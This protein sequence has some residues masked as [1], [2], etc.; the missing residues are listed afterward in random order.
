MT[1]IVL[2]L[3]TTGLDPKQGHKIVEIGAI[4]LKN[5]LLT[6]DKFHRY[7]NPERDMPFQAYNIHGISSSFLA[8]KPIFKDVVDELLEFIKDSTLI[9]HNASFDVKFLNYELALLGRE[10]INVVNVIDTLRVAQNLYPGKKASLDA[11]C[12]RFKV[13]LS[14][15]KLHGALKDAELLA[16]VYYMMTGGVNQ[17]SLEVEQNI[18]EM[19]DF[20]VQRKQITARTIKPT[21]TELEAHLQLIKKMQNS[22]WDTN[23]DIPKF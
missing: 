19:A 22:I 21:Q 15:R 13:D 9:I 10:A 5:K 3:E 6:N 16:K 1:E 18:Q 23:K 20:K 11:L 4:K 17:Y 2:D 14:N 7:V 8:D 12:D